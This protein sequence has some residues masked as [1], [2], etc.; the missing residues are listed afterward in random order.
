MAI[1]SD[2]RD[3]RPQGGAEHASMTDGQGGKG[4]G[5][6]KD[7]FAELT[8]PTNETSMRVDIMKSAQEH[9]RAETGKEGKDTSGKSSDRATEQQRNH[10]LF[11][12]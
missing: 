9:H 5:G 1:E 12:K 7:P 11:N 3:K 4:G 10:D 6:E 2:R 8:R